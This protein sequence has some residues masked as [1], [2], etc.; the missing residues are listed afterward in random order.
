MGQGRNEEKKAQQTVTEK[1]NTWKS[2]GLNHVRDNTCLP[3]ESTLGMHFY[4][5]NSFVSTNDEE[6]VRSASFSKEF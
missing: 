3:C 6:Y 1:K 2:T 5:I 4:Q